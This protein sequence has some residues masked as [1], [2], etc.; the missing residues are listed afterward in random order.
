[1]SDAPGTDEPCYLPPEQ[2]RIGIFVMLD[3]P[4][5]RHSFALNNFTIRTAEQLHEVRKLGLP[6]YR[7]DPQ[8]SESVETAA[9]EKNQTPPAT[10]TPASSTE[11]DASRDKRQRMQA[12]KQRHQQISRVEKAFGKAVAVMKNLNQN[13]I[14]RPQATLDEASQLVGD[15][16]DAFIDSREATIHIMG[17]KAG[18]EE[19]YFHGL[20]TS[21]LAMMLA[22]DM[23]FSSE[24][25][26][27]LGIGALM[28]DI[29][30]SAIPEK[31]LKK[32]PDE[33][34]AAERQLRASHVAHGIEFGQR[35]GLS[36]AALAI[37][38]QH[39]E[40][41]DGSGYPQRL[42]E[43]A[44]DPGARLVSLVNFYDNLCNPI[45]IA[46]ALTPH[47][48]L[49]FMFAQRRAKFEARAMQYLVRSLGVYPPGSIVKLSNDM[50][51]TVISINPKKP[52]RPWVMLYDAKVP[53]EEA[54]V[55]N[56][57]QDARITI[58]QSIR[59][60]LLPPKVVIYLNPRKRVTY[61]FDGAQE[62]SL[63]SLS[64]EGR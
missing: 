1:M 43:D 24:A 60:A 29:G 51:A 34:T 11:S 12:L 63:T 19:V 16:V 48:A 33:Y 26:H 6:R 35:I 4:W 49:S 23:G 47:E 57:D 2:L 54:P 22:K 14:A 25:A 40:M 44:M 20:N 5:F 31:L 10:S 42:K 15:M 9:Q 64:P 32:A 18:G 8:R 7:Y 61:F 21:I 28:H 13:L 56:L 3:I 27:Q 50:L 59:P 41:A 45:D 55:L 52:L 36:A 58:T 46:K 62:T 53:R 38:A 30:L 17:E 37:V 39:H